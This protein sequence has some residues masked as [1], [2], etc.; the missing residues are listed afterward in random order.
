MSVRYGGLLREQK[1]A[2]IER[3]YASLSSTAGVNKVTVKAL[4]EAVKDE[5]GAGSIGRDYISKFLDAR[6]IRPRAVAPSPPRQVHSE[7]AELELARAVLV[8][9]GRFVVAEFTRGTGVWEMFVDYNA[10]FGNEEE[11]DISAYTIKFWEGDTFYR[12]KMSDFA[13]YA[14]ALEATGHPRAAKLLREWLEQ[15]NTAL[16]LRVE[17]SEYVAKR[18]RWL[19]L[20][21]ELVISDPEY[22]DIHRTWNFLST[23]QPTTNLREYLRFEDSS[24]ARLL[25]AVCKLKHANIPLWKYDLDAAAFKLVR[26]KAEFEQNSGPTVMNTGATAFGFEYNFDDYYE[27]GSVVLYALKQTPLGPCRDEQVDRII[28]ASPVGDNPDPNAFKLFFPPDAQPT[29]GAVVTAMLQ[30]FTKLGMPWVAGDPPGG[31]PQC[32]NRLG[33]PVPNRGEWGCF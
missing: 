2:L 21:S 33:N 4:W 31:S 3:A 11:E 8:T 10:S 29:R 32:M 18:K 30:Y 19:D 5:N 22:G 26:T 9:V 15:K 12:T 20:V 23:Y 1:D 7:E 24:F 28:D 17:A 14:Y 27:K 25:T 6:G 16:D 13:K